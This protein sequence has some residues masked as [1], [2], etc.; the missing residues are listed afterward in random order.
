MTVSH[1]EPSVPDLQTLKRTNAI[2]GCNRR[3]FMCDYLTNKQGFKPENIKRFDSLDEYPRSLENNEI[4]AAIL[5]A[6]QAEIFLATYC[7]GY[8]T[9]GTPLTLVGLGFVFPR[10][11]RLAVDMSEAVLESIERGEVQDLKKKMLS[12]T[13][14]RSSDDAEQDEKLGPQP[15]FGL[16]YISGTIASLGLVFTMVHFAGRNVKT[17]KTWQ[18]IRSMKR[19]LIPERNRQGETFTNELL[20]IC[21]R[22]ETCPRAAYIF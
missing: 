14:C 20:G 3:S 21:F 13:N 19:S 15:F 9:A 6:P 22:T 8:I 16:F 17:S 10:G 11:S 2:V 7:K 12:T 4:K 18:R 1:L 5:I